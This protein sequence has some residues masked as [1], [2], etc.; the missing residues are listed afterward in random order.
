ML[1]LQHAKRVSISNGIGSGKARAA[2]QMC[3]M[4]CINTL[5]D[6]GPRQSQYVGRKCALGDAKSADLNRWTGKRPK[7][8]ETAGI[9]F[10]KIRPIRQDPQPLRAD[11][12]TLPLNHHM[13]RQCIKVISVQPSAIVKARIPQRLTCSD[14]VW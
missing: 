13:V 4:I 9:G 11:Q 1:G 12:N 3:D 10:R 6:R 7:V 8:I 5:R 2:K 14:V